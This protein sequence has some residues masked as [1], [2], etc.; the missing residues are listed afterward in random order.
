MHRMATFL[1]WLA[2]AT[3]STLAP[4]WAADAPPP[5][6]LPAPGGGLPVGS[7]V[8]A[9]TDSGRRDP[10]DPSQ[11]RVLLVQL[12][13]P[14]QARAGQHSAPYIQEPELVAMLERF[15]SLQEIR[16]SLGAGGLGRVETPAILDA[17]VSRRRRSFPV[18]VFSPGTGMPRAFYSVLA[19]RLASVGFFIAVIDHPGVGVAAIPG[20]GIVGQFEPMNQP[21]P[22]LGQRPEEE[23]DRFWAPRNEMLVADQLYVIDQLA[24]LNDGTI[25]SRFR[26]RIDLNR[27]A[28][29][30]H[31]SGFQSRACA[32]SRAR[33]CVD[34]EGVAVLADRRSGLDRPLLSVRDGQDSPAQTAILPNMRAEAYDVLVQGSNHNSSTD[35]G[36][37]D[38][39]PS[40]S[41]R[42]YM[43]IISTYLREFLDQSLNGRRS[44]LLASPRSPYET[45]V[46]T[47]DSAPSDGAWLISGSLFPVCKAGIP[48][49]EAL[50]R[51]RGFASRQSRA[52]R[53]PVFML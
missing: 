27:L 46:M 17:P 19:S 16:A 22:G 42:R 25:G 32:R 51:C 35:L 41:T 31:S 7:T 49:C 10:I 12:W 50:R 1:L 14:A 9:W 11:S 6:R 20:R 43:E 44:T 5:V 21:P 13:Y 24:H 28:V 23:R 33:A 40:E 29:G 2:T 34:I 53:G 52:D 38:P 3:A 30:G 8:F 47:R 15:S 36:F 45:G 39:A 48:A 37:L 4:S 26:G 18:L